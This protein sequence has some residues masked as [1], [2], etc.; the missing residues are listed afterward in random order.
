MEGEEVLRGWNRDFPATHG[1]DHD[2]DC[3]A[4]G[5]PPLARGSPW[6]GR[7]PP[8]GHWGGPRKEQVFWPGPVAH[9]ESVPA[10]GC[11]WRTAP[12]EGACTG[13]VPEELL[14]VGRTHTGQVFE[15]LSAMRGTS[16][17]SRGRLWRERNGRGQALWTDHNPHS[18]PPCTAQGKK[19]GELGVNPCLGR[20][21]AMG[22]K[23]FLDFF[24][25][26]ICRYPTLINW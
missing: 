24:F 17:W 12:M 22:R 19:R 10:A 4:A 9:Q 16:H 8:A 25:L 7:Y 1:D 11:S 6:W 2:G 5:C 18:P 15:G 23:C 3:G 14:P 20:R 13:A 21:E 26:F